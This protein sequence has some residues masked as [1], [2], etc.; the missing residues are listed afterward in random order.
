MTDWPAPYTETPGQKTTHTRSHT[1]HRGGGR[2]R[3]STPNSLLTLRALTHT[4]TDSQTDEREGEGDGE[5]EH[6]TVGTSSPPPA[7]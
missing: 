7:R 4:E 6:K 3:Y 5:R 1:L 2:Q